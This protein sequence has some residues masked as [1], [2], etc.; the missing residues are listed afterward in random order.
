MRHPVIP[1]MWIKLKIAIFGI[2]KMWKLHLVHIAAVK[3]FMFQF[4]NIY[5]YTGLM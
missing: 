1:S 4:T 3:Y 5:D 2:N